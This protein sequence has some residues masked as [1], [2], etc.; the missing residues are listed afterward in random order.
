MRR[1]RS[2]RA[3]L[4]LLLLLPLLGG[5]ALWAG[6]SATSPGEPVV[7]TA[8]VRRGPLVVRVRE[9]GVVVPRLAVE[10][11]S[12]VGGRIAR[13]P[14]NE[15]D[16]VE[17]GT[18]LAEIDPDESVSRVRQAEADLASA[19]A[20]L[21]ALLEGTRPQEIAQA[22][23]ELA[24]AEIAL[25]DAEQTVRRRQELAAQGFIA[26]A[27]LDAAITQREMA[28]QAVARAREALSLAREGARRQDI[29]AA[30]AEVLRA[31]DALRNARERL[32]DTVVRA[33]M[34]GTI[35][36][37]LVNPG[38]IVTAGNLSTSTGT[39]MMVVADLSQLLVRTK[40]N[41]VDVPKIRLGQPAEVVVDAIRE[42]TW[43]A[44]VVR[45]APAGQ[46][47]ADKNL[48]TF[49]VDVRLLER[50]DR[51]RPDM[52]AEVDILVARAEDTLLVPSEALVRQDDPAGGGLRA[53]REVL[54]VRRGEG[55]AARFEPVP[56][57]V[58]LR[59]ETLVEVLAGVREGDVVRLPDLAA[60]SEAPAGPRRGR[61]RGV[62]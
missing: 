12:K 33:P 37:R 26:R 62:H 52:T 47:E 42:R 43:R 48:V 6:R 38:E 5:A 46:R 14:V 53:R 45:I 59:T 11:K 10:V 18:V 15:G 17:T 39:L 50:D 20:R 41:E 34:S 49:E 29:L 35:L 24:R 2:S 28:R 56:V 23:A 19:R 8:V 32:R 61:P 30:Q 27:D 58:G 36:R 31:E 44:E 1:P 57:T 25:A 16:T 7:R 55:P 13:L 51:I 4:A 21:S 22:E 9:T 40:V 3:R 54:F 60:S